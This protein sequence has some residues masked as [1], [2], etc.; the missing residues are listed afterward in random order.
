M[1]IMMVAAVAGHGTNPGLPSQEG[2]LC[3]LFLAV[4]GLML[5]TAAALIVRREGSN[6]VVRYARSHRRTNGL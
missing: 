5:L 4:A 3:C 2:A 1:N 6:H